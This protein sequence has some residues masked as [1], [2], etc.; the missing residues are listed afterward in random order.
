VA[1]A[2][3]VAD[4]GVEGVSVMKRVGR[5]RAFDTIDSMHRHCGKKDIFPS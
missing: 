4:V 2:A 5:T 3:D 1:D